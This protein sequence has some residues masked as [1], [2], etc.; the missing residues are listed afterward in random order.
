MLVG[1]RPWASSSV[2]IASLI[3]ERA[4]GFW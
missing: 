3:G 1:A 4:L 2:T